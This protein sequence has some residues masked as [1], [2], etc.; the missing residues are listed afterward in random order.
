MRKLFWQFFR[1]GI[2]GV[3]ATLLDFL[4]LYLFVDG[5]GWSYLLGAA[6][7]F[8]LS[9]VFNYLA[10]MRFV[11]Q[12]RF[13]SAERQKEVLLFVSLSLVGLGLNQLLLWILVSFWQVYYLLAKVFVTAVVFLW[14]FI[15]RKVFLE[16][17]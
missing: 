6:L 10:S 11:F 14:N 9:T 7:S 17:N 16:A 5:F 15:S 8:T 4:L 3:L 1:F 13:T 2:V 12:S